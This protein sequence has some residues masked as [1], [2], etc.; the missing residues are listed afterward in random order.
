MSKEPRMVKEPETQ[1]MA[2]PAA[3]AKP[4]PFAMEKVAAVVDSKT[5]ITKD[6]KTITMHF[7]KP[8]TLSLN[9]GKKVRFGSGI[10]EV[11]EYL[12]NHWYLE[13]SGVKAYEKN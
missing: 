8:I 13:V 11:P 7:P 4:L 5:L 2:E 6:I 10:Q 12:A 1:A 3:V 9:T